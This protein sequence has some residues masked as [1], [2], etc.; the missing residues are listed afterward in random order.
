M[1]RWVELVVELGCHK[2][3]IYNITRKDWGNNITSTPETLTQTFVLEVQSLLPVHSS[4]HSALSLTFTSTLFSHLH[5]SLPNGVWLQ[6]CIPCVNQGGHSKTT[7]WPTSVGEGWCTY[8]MWN[9]SLYNGHVADHLRHGFPGESYF[10]IN[11]R[12]HLHITFLVSE[13]FTTKFQNNLA[14][15]ASILRWSIPT[16]FYLNVML[17]STVLH[18]KYKSSPVPSFSFVNKPSSDLFS[19]SAIQ[20]NLSLLVGLR[21]HSIRYSS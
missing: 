10:V 13:A 8:C 19:P 17:K 3:C 6:F 4:A 12:E 14:S 2:K 9:A 5:L 21:S 20:W 11:R 7:W 1:L 15:S 16:V 18:N